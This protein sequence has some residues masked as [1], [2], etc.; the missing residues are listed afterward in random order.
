MSKIA[1]LSRDTVDKIA[2]GEVVERP[3]SVVKELTEN[4]ID[5]GADAVTVE[6]RDGG[7]SLIRI[8]DNGSGI[9]ADEVRTAFLP[10]ATSK[11]STADDLE[12]IASLGFRG[13]ALPSICAVSRMEVITRSRSALE[14]VRLCM[15]GG[16]EK[17]FEIIGAPEGSTFIVR[18][19]FY[20]TPA[21]KKFL[22]SAASEAGLISD[23]AEHLALS[24]PEISM[25]LIINGQVRLHTS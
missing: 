19:L 24:H 18:D 10:H 5:A 16:T 23:L 4:A 12:R 2:A 17:S 20:N 7:T 25:K 15:E 6:I 22:K 13:E 9:E 1:V 21:R 3:S 8:T 11:I 14:G